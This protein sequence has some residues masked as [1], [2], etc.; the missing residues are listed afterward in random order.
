MSLGRVE[1]GCESQRTAENGRAQLAGAV[2]KAA[3]VT[4]GIECDAGLIRR[5]HF[6]FGRGKG[7]SWEGTST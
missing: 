7:D 1:R 2:E 4:S 3:G 6:G 5:C